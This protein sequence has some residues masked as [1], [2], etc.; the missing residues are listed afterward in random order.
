[1]AIL[2]IIER[3]K[4]DS[5]N[6]DDG[7]NFGPSVPCSISIVFPLLFVSSFVSSSH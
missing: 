4:Q 6:R 2:M 7:T 3:T 5:N 1:M